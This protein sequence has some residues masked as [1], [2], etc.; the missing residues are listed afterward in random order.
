MLK[1]VLDTNVLVSATVSKGTCF[2]LLRRADAGEVSLFLSFDIIQEFKEVISRRKF[3]YDQEHVESVL[4][5]LIGMTNL[6][7]SPPRIDVIEDDPKD[8]VILACA[9]SI[10][11]D[12]LVSGDEH[13][14]SLNEF[15]GTRIVSPKEMLEILNK[16]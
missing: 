6:I 7:E 1:I 14:L 13:L 4:N 11:A 16:T 5:K 2:E 15:K 3:G 10:N 9:L 12:Y 8:N